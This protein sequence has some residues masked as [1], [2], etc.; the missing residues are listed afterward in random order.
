MLISDE[1][2]D[3]AE[4]M[5]KYGGSFVKALGEALIHAD[6]NNIKRIKATWPEYWNQYLNFGKDKKS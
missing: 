5:I 6:L 2:V 4:N 1:R 3:V